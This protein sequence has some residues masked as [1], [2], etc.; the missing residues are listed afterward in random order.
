[1]A[2]LLRTNV[3]TIYATLCHVSLIAK[4]VPQLFASAYKFFFAR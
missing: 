3:E 4:R 1:M 2:L